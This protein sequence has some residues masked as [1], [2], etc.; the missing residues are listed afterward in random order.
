MEVTPIGWILLL[1]GPV[2][3]VLRPRWLYVATIFFLPFTATDLINVGN[4]MNLPGPASLNVSGIA[5]N[6]A[7]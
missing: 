1:V 6:I 3:M 2:L 4:D 5:A 7:I